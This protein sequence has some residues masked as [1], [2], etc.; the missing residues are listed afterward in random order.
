MDL[1]I[2]KY[3]HYFAVFAYTAK[4]AQF[5]RE[6]TNRFIEMALV[7]KRGRFMNAPTRTYARRDLKKEETCFHINSFADFIKE[8]EKYQWSGVK[9]DLIEIPL[10][11]PT[12]VKFKGEITP[13]ENQVP[14]IEFGS[15]AGIQR[16]ITAQP[17]FGKTLCSLAIAKENGT[18]FATVTLGGFED[19]WIPEFYDKLGLKPDEVRSCCGCTKLYRLLREVKAK[20]FKKVKAIFI[21]NGALRD[22]YKNWSNGKVVGSGC[23]DIDPA[24]LWEYLGVGLVIIDEAHKEF[25]SH[26]IS[27]LYSHVPKKIYLTATLFSKQQFILD[28]YELVMPRRLRKEGGKINK[29]VDVVKV[30]YNLKDWRKAKFIGGQGSY[31]HT[32]YE[33]WIMADKDRKRNYTE[34]IYEYADNVWYKGR[35]S[36][37]KLLVFASTIDLCQHF[38][39]TFSKKWPELKVNSFT[40]GDDYQT[41]LDSHVIFST[42]GKSG[43]AVDIPDLTQAILTVAVDSPNANIQALGRL[44]ELKGEKA[45]K[46]TYHCFVCNNIDKHIDYWK[47]KE[48]LFS[49]RI[50]GISTAHLDRVI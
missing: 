27:D 25:H 8:A 6:F 23:E 12:K 39:Q 13:W 3:S 32:T 45:F 30:V 49:G 21:S 20:T 4:G 9:Y 48:R 14:I 33:Q 38:S 22:F 17:G 11:E 31:S 28:M 46:Q 43:T 50:T 19:R 24:T 34:A 47:G 40:S 2:T 10:Y 7:K 35:K 1:R 5:R 37:H 18:R 15:S 29:Y 26:A 41:L 42:L 16:V 36:E 44:R